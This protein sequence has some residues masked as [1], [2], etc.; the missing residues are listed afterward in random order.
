MLGRCCRVFSPL[1][2]LVMGLAGEVTA[3]LYE[4]GDAAFRRK[5][6]DAALDHWRPLANAGD[7]RAQVG[8]ARMYYAGHGVALDY[9]EAF[10]WCSKASE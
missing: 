4:D 9:S 2:L 3:G 10:D 7:A 1:L 5:D 6:Y 8:L